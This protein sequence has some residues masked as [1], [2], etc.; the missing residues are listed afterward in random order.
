MLWIEHK[1]SPVHL[2][3]GPFVPPAGSAGCAPAAFGSF[4]EGWGK[5]LQAA[6]LPQFQQSLSLPK[7]R[8]KFCCYNSG[9][10]VSCDST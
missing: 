7:M 10:A 6:E 8:L 5:R 3:F 1:S 9:F 2:L 4:S